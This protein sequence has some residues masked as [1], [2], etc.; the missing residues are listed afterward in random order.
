MDDG[1]LRLALVDYLT[2]SPECAAGVVLLVDEAHR[3]PLRL[4]EEIRT[5]TDLARGGQPH[6]RLV[7][8]GGCALEERLAHPRLGALSQRMVARCY[9]E[10]LNRTET[11]AYVHAQIARVGGRADLLFPAEACQ[12][13]FQATGGVPRLINQVCDHG[14]LLACTSGRRRVESAVVEEAWA[15]LQQLPTP[16]SDE[17][18]EQKGGVIE[19]GGLDDSSDLSDESSPV[20]EAASL[21]PFRITPDL[22]ELETPEGDP[23]QQLEEIEQML[24]KA[25]G[26][27]EPAG[28]IGPELELV[29]EDPFREEFE[30]EEPVADRCVASDDEG[31]EPADDEASARP[32][33]ARIDAARGTGRKTL[34]LCGEASAEDLDDDRS[35]G[36]SAAEDLAAGA[37]RTTMT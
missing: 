35:A 27:F 18:P 26:D 33:V 36:D 4:M 19:F 30:E 16:W 5:L 21:P 12:S 13:V 15:D 10:A 24:C 20:A 6:V 28:S 2:T 29:F 14:L 31:A 1:E 23:G 3:L 34:S 37:R 25:G 32:L 11:Q 17:T 22:E 9:L 7:L 8:V